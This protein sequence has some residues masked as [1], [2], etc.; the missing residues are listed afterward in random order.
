MG[1]NEVHFKEVE[2]DRKPQALR[3]E[4]FYFPLCMLFVG[5]LAS[6][7]CFIAEI[8]IHCIGKS[9]TKV[10]VLTLVEPPVTQSTSELIEDTKI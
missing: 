1:N 5:I 7:L 2:D 4:H 6:I 10:P 3:M 8:I 9:K